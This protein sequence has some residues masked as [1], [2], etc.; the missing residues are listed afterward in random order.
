MKVT[1]EF[2]SLPNV[3]K[4]VGGKSVTL[5][6]GGKTVDDLVCEVAS[7]YGQDVRDF[8]LD[9]SGHLDPALRVI[10]NKKEWLRRD[11]LDRGINDGDL[12]TIAMLLG[13]G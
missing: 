6:F 8:L 9:E 12:V 7:K 11:Q 1:V 4:L 13:G 5:D 2:L 10:L 3:V